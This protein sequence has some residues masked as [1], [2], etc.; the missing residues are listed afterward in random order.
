[1]YMYHYCTWHTRALGDY[2]DQNAK[3]FFR[4]QEHARPLQLMGSQV[5]SHQVAHLLA[6]S[7]P[8]GRSNLLRR[9]LPDSRWCWTETQRMLEPTKSMNK[10][11]T[12]NIPQTCPTYYC[13]CKRLWNCRQTATDPHA[14]SSVPIFNGHSIH[15]PSVKL[16][17]ERRQYQTIQILSLAFVPCTLEQFL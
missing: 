16:A 11:S 6:L 10:L 17:L 9:H 14:K 8:S 13:N 1:M 5:A 4:A 12:F 2:A 15:R 3:N 7:R